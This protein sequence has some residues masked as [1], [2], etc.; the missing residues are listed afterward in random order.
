MLSALGHVVTVAIWC[1]IVLGVIALG[2]T[3]LHIV[4]R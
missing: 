4:A 3:L 1:F 2:Q